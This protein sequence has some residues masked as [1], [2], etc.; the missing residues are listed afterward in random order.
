MQ[1]K[2]KVNSVPDLV[3]GNV[4]IQRFSIITF[5]IFSIVLLPGMIFNTLNGTYYISINELKDIS[6]FSMS[7]SVA[8]AAIGLSI[9]N[10]NCKNTGN[11]KEKMLIRYILNTLVLISVSFFGYVT[12]ISKLSELTP[13][14]VTLLGLLILFSLFFII[15]LTFSIIVGYFNIRN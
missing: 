4:R 12:S 6:V 10:F 13:K 14:G 2:K 1:N 11:N 15:V 8:I 7:T 5:L 3:F 9:F